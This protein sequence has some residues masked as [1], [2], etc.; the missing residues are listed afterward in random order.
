MDEPWWVRISS[1]STIQMNPGPFPFLLVPDFWNARLLRSSPSTPDS[2]ALKLPVNSNHKQVIIS[3]IQ[4]SICC[5]VVC[6]MIFQPNHI[7]SDRPDR[8]TIQHYRYQ[9]CVN[10]KLESPSSA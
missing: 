8:K 4:P 9:K 10:G 2:S 7:A 3:T 1:S 5:K 6:T